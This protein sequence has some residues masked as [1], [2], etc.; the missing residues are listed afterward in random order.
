MTPDFSSMPLREVIART[1]VGEADILGLKGMQAT[2]NTGQNRVNSG[3]RTFGSDL[4]GVFTWPEQYSCWNP[5]NQRMPFLLKMS[6]D[7]PMLSAALVLADQALAGTLPDITNS[8]THYFNHLI[9]DRPPDSYQG[10]NLFVL[11][12]HWYYRAK[13]Y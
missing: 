12:P 2:I 13:P 3:V 6:D 9:V 1:A 8:S 4:V 11:D 5:D 7:D 10:V